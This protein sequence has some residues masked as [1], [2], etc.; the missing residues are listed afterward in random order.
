MS[1]QWL[2]AVEIIDMP[3]PAATFDKNAAVNNNHHA[4]R[5]EGVVLVE[6]AEPNTTLMR[7]CRSRAK[8]LD[9]AS[10][11]TLQAGENLHVRFGDAALKLNHARYEQANCR[12]SIVDSD[13]D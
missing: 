2:Q 13:S 11:D 7:V 10:W 8:L 4:A 3:L 12:I 6:P 5:I 9:R 1:E